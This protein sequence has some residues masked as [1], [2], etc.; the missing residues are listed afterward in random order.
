MT[1]VD[2]EFDEMLRRALHAAA[3]R[4][5]P[6]DGG[7]ERIRRR[8][9]EPW[10]RRQASLMLTECAD[11]GQLIAIWLEPAVGRLRP[12]LTEVRRSAGAAFAWLGSHVPALAAVRVR[13]RTAFAR[14]HDAA[15][16]GQPQRGWARLQPTL[17]WLR[18]TLAVLCAVF[19]VVAGVYGLAQLR[20][21]L[22][23]QVVPGTASSSTAPGHAGRD[24]SAHAHSVRPSA[25][26]IAPAS[27]SP[28]SASPSPSPSCSPISKITQSPA[29]TQSASPTSTGSPSASPSASPSSSPT[30]TGTSLSSPL[31][32]SASPAAAAGRAGSLTLGAVGTR[33]G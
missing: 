14:R 25:G 17:V 23:L 29:P 30:P 31:P 22:V 7:L 21:T 19:V 10:L 1:P 5:E 15:H 4:I 9:D 27:T 18:P 11:L 20:E 3:D 12:A 26:W 33:C 6:A 8:L 13:V 24:P 32:M 16:R 28:G 2:R